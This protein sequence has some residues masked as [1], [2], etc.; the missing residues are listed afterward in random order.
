MAKKKENKDHLPDAHPKKRQAR[1]AQAAFLEAF[2]KFGTIL[3][4][5]NEIGIDRSTYRLWKEDPKFAELFADADEGVTDELEGSAL[6]NA[7]K[8]KGTIDRIFLLKARRPEKYQEKKDPASLGADIVG[9]IIGAI[10]AARSRGLIPNEPIN[11]TATD[12]EDNQ[13]PG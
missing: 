7:K 3:R 5:C 4:A 11:T 8:P 1:V 6:D 13:R 10:Q 2:K 9:G 12:N